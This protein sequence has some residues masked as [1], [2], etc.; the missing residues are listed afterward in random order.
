MTISLDPKSAKRI[1]VGLLKEERNK[2]FQNISELANS[3]KS[4]DAQKTNKKKLVVEAGYQKCYGDMTLFNYWDSR[5][6]HCWCLEPMAPTDTC[7][8]PYF[9]IV[10]KRSYN[11]RSNH[12]E[13]T[14]YLEIS[15][16]AMERMLSRKNDTRL[17]LHIREEITVAFLNLYMTELS[18]W[19][20]TKKDKSIKLKTT[21]GVACV[22]FP[23]GTTEFTDI[24]VMTT[25]Y[26]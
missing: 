8:R 26:P 1:V 22:A 15:T 4:S 12:Q 17:M 20:D 19:F 9:G 25:W 7:N 3:S 11:L 5:T 6:Y 13:I 18:D 2:A 16:H 21:N 24:P 14:P 23:D 10:T